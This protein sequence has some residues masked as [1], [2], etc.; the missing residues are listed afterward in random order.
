MEGNYTVTPRLPQ[1]AG[2][3]AVGIVSQTEGTYQQGQ[4]VAF[5]HPG[6]WAEFIAVPIKSLSPISDSLPTDKAAQLFLNPGMAWGLLKQARLEAGDW[7]LL[8][9]GNSTVA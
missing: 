5:R 6:A 8:T 4:R 3:D 2:F 1:I 9:A 7:L